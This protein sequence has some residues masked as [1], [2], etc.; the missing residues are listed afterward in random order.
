MADF[1]LGNQGNNDWDQNQDYSGWDQEQDSNW[2]QGQNQEYDDWDQNQGGGSWG[3]NQGNQY[4]YQWDQGQNQYNQWNQYQVNGGKSGPSKKVIIGGILGGI[5]GILV[6][7]GIIGNIIGPSEKDNIQTGQGNTE[8]IL[9]NNT[10]ISDDTTGIGDI[11]EQPNIS[12]GIDDGQIGEDKEQLGED[13]KQI[14]EDDKQ[15]GEDGKQI[16]EDGKQIGEDGYDVVIDT[17][18]VTSENIDTIQLEDYT[19]GDTITVH[20]SKGDFSIRFNSVEETSDRNLQSDFSPM[21]VILLNYTVQN[22]SYSEQFQVLPFNL[23]VLDYLGDEMRQYHLN[24]DYGDPINIGESGDITIAY[25]LNS[26]ENKITIE[27][28][29]NTNWEES[30]RFTA[31]LSNW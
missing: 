17:E 12:N 11:E 14:V 3:Q 2:D 27:Y 8:E 28:Y 1:N 15:I 19:I 5:L 26:A 23:K 24:T 20:T 4:D 30:P 29:T 21:R 22:I 25:G 7:I 10:D 6:I 16:G 18:E 9:E 13:D 31:V